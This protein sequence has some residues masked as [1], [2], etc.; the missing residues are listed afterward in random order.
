MARRHLHEDHVNHEAWAIPY[1]DL[2][3]LLLAFFVVMY[4]VSSLNEGKYRVASSSLNAAFGGR[5]TSML[6]VNVGDVPAQTSSAA[7]V[8]SG[9]HQALPTALIATRI[10]SQLPV[11]ARARWAEDNGVD[12]ETEAEQKQLAE[13]AKQMEDTL[14]SLILNDQVSV[15]RQD[16]WIEVDIKADAL[17]A[18]GSAAPREAALPVL[19][20]IAGVLRGNRHLVRIEGHTDSQPIRTL[21]YPSNWELS[22][23]RASSVVRLFTQQGIDPGLMQVVGY[24]D[25]Q[26]ISDN[27]SAA[28]RTANRRVVL[29]VST[30]PASDIEATGVNPAQ[31]EPT[32]PAPVPTASGVS[33]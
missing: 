23:A 5:A 32:A 25:T 10:N 1:G 22:A 7:S 21:Q 33:R 9:I 30:R 28:G 27:T 17:F 18:S 31:P 3:T 16:D 20:Q 15:Y 2:L 14:S 11:D 26:P 29:V 12:A 8:D 6:P 4:S 24:G 19:Q 13:T